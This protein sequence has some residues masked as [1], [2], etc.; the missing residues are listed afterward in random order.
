MI[1]YILIPE[2]FNCH[3][4]YSKDLDEFFS[5]LTEEDYL[6]Y[7]KIN[8]E[9]L[10]EFYKNNKYKTIKIIKELK[11]RGFEFKEEKETSFLSTIFIPEEYNK[12]IYTDIN[13]QKYKEINKYI[14]DFLD[15]SLINDDRFFNGIPLVG[16]KNYNENIEDTLIEKEFL[17]Y[18]YKVLSLREYLNITKI[19]NYN[20]H[21]LI[22][23]IIDISNIKKIAF[24]EITHLNI[25]E[26]YDSDKYI[27]LESYMKQNNINLLADFITNFNSIELFLNKYQMNNLIY[28]I[29]EYLNN[30][31]YKLDSDE[32]K[33]ILLKEKTNDINMEKDDLLNKMYQD[34]NIEDIFSNLSGFKA[35]LNKLRKEN[36]KNLLDYD[37]QISNNNKFNNII[38]KFKE[39]LQ[40]DIDDIF[41]SKFELS[42]S[43]YVLIKDKNIY[44]IYSFLNRIDNDFTIKDLNLLDKFKSMEIFDIYNKPYLDFEK[45]HRIDLYRFNKKINNTLDLNIFI[46]NFILSS[47]IDAR[48]LLICQER[49][50]NKKTLDETGQKFEITRERIRQITKQI[51]KQFFSNHIQENFKKIL[52]F[53]FVQNIIEYSDI[54]KMIKTDYILFFELFKLNKSKFI[55][56]YPL[57]N[58]IY[59]LDKKI[60]FDNKKFN[61]KI[62]NIINEIDIIGSYEQIIYSLKTLEDEL[63][64]L[65]NDIIENIFE[66]YKIRKIKNQYIILKDIKA[67]NDRLEIYM[68]YI[69]K[70]FL[71]LS[72]NKNIDKLNSDFLIYFGEET[73]RTSRSWE[74]I[75]SR[76]EELILINPRTY[77]HINNL[78]IDMSEIDFIKN[79]IDKYLNEMDFIYADTLY[80]DLE[81]KYSNIAIKSKHE[82]YSL[83]K[84]FYIDDFNF[85]TGNSLK[86]SKKDTL[87]QTNTEILYSIC[88]EYKKPITYKEII[89]RTQ[90]SKHRIEMAISNS[91]EIIKFGT[92]KCVI[93]NNLF[94]GNEKELF[95]NK[96]QLLFK[97]KFTSSNIILKNLIFSEDLSEFISR[98]NLT[99][100]TA[101]TSLIK[102]LNKDIEGHTV[103]LYTKDSPVKSIDDLI[104]FKYKDGFNRKDIENLMEKL[105]FS[106]GSLHSLSRKLELFIENKEY[107][108]LNREE[109]IR[110]ENF[111]LD[112]DFIEKIIKFS[113][114]IY[115]KNNYIIP[116]KII[117]TIKKEIGNTKYGL[118]QYIITNILIEH[119]YKRIHRFNEDYRYEIIVLV[120]N[121]SKYDSLN[122]L[123]YDLLI[124]D[125][126][127]EWHEIPIYDYLSEKGFYTIEDAKHKKFLREDIT[128]DL[129]KIDNAG[130]VKLK[131]VEN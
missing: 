75:I 34:S 103:F 18:G 120:K 116:N 33:E 43:L 78:K 15:Y 6:D 42:K 123:V 111:N 20:C 14:F 77:I 98:N 49:Y 65:T 122:Y 37:N 8:L 115:E 93:P 32:N 11:M 12:F 69:Y 40:K 28:D 126:K 101:L 41:N 71:D 47:N 39:Q 119:G 106:E 52:N 72:N 87:K 64:Q 92:N 79:Q 96:I 5:N 61:D 30:S 95:K 63:G 91:D 50:I 24:E 55:G 117:S 4:I 99:D 46:D 59:L 44:E 113:D 68:K 74:G 35:P 73:T 51:E 48:T 23:E 53:L 100:T 26:L 16:F 17:R 86:F 114:E 118:N 107:L 104:R 10:R 90:W 124:S 109:Y 112:D 129:I 94:I 66:L 29:L 97:D 88:N 110:Y 81:K 9:Y 56:Y 45:N 57:T 21:E 76:I 27:N 13:T 38:N 85:A 108:P 25:F 60:S 67:N 84:Y 62:K 7:N 128:I 121:N 80:L 89:A 3:T 70:D 54:E 125:Y 131:E 31:F 36:I 22:K 105:Q 1:E 130:R 58:R 82:M 127:G 2:Y 19:K 102:Y 83:I